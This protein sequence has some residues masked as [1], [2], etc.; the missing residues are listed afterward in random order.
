MI[1]DMCSID[2]DVEEKPGAL[3]FSHP[4]SRDECVKYHICQECEE[5]IFELM[6][7]KAKHE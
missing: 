7:R 1:C 2:F 3:F 5:A 4:C 6:N